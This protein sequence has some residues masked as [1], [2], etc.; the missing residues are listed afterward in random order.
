MWISRLALRAA[1]SARSAWPSGARF[2]QRHRRGLRR[3]AGADGHL[4]ELDL[5]GVQD[6]ARRR[7][8][9]VDANR[10]GALEALARQVDDERQIVVVGR[11]GGRKSLGGSG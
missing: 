2:V 9:D 3:G 10:L 7:L 6:D 8:G 5:D 4:A 1:A 11:D